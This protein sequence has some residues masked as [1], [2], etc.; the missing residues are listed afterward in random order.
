MYKRNR[1]HVSIDEIKNAI[2]SSRSMGESA[3]VLGI[4]SRTFKR[5]ATEYGL[6]HSGSN[7][8]GMKYDIKD[9]FD[10][11]YPQYPTSKLSKR[12]VSEG[13]KDYKCEIC[14]I[15]EWNNSKISLELDH[16]DGNSR[17][18]ALHNL[19][20]LCPNCHS[21]TPTY[22]NKRGKSKQIGDCS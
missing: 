2:D 5:I 1:I 7:R 10:G 8:G 12:L 17:N 15:P 16:I 18:H 14:G 11:K 20:I 9:I 19:R 13:F 21:Q 6:Y 22:R 4:D 3:A